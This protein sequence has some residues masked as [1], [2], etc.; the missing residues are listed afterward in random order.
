[1][2]AIQI[3]EIHM[4]DIYVA[5]RLDPARNRR[6]IQSGT[7]HLDGC[8][9]Q[10]LAC[11]DWICQLHADRTSQ[12]GETAAAVGLDQGLSNLEVPGEALVGAHK[13][14]AAASVNTCTQ[15]A[16]VN[17]HTQSFCDRT[18]TDASVLLGVSRYGL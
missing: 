2:A 15:R 11:T 14:A 16:S 13:A 3:S 9:G 10:A 1:M 8:T 7:P 12:A 4:S 18:Q 5:E 6:G 17:A